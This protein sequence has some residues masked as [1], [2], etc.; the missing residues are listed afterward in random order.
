MRK[1]CGL[2]LGADRPAREPI[3]K[4]NSTNLQNQFPKL[5]PGR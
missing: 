3:L 4:R 5:T 2:R 1:K